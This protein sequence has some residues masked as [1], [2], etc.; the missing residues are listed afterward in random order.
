VFK[1]S[2][3]LSQTFLIPR[4]IERNMI[5]LVHWSSCKVTLFFEF[6]VPTNTLSYTIKY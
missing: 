3:T 2:L 6:Y 1:L 5:K 4:R